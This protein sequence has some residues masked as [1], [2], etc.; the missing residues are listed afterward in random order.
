MEALAAPAGH[1]IIVVDV[2][3][4]RVPHPPPPPRGRFDPLL[5]IQSPW[6]QLD[7]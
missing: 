2:E 4:L 5:A 7:Q 3:G 6:P 1:A